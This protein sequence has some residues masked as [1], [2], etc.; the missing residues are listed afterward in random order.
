MSF[1]RTFRHATGHTEGPTSGPAPGSLA[2]KGPVSLNLATGEITTGEA[3][4][5]APVAPAAPVTPVAPVSTTAPAATPF[6]MAEGYPATPAP[7]TLSIDRAAAAEDVAIERRLILASAAY[8][9]RFTDAELQRL[10]RHVLKAI[11]DDVGTLEADR[12]LCRDTGRAPMRSMPRPYLLA[13]A[14][15]ALQEKPAGL[16]SSF[17]SGGLDSALRTASS[18]EPLPA[19]DGGKQ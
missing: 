11:A 19:G 14:K 17:N 5:V 16:P 15:N 7:Y 18:D 4:R 2:G 8:G 6:R 3:A 9:K 1:F 10:P 12:R 13:L